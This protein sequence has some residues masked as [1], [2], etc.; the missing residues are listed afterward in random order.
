M[1]SWLKKRRFKRHRNLDGCP[2][3]RSAVSCDNRQQVCLFERRRSLRNT[4]AAHTAKEVSFRRSLTF[5]VRGSGGSS[6]TKNASPGS[7][8]RG[9]WRH[10]FRF[11]ENKKRRGHQGTGRRR[12]PHSVLA[13]AARKEASSQWSSVPLEVCESPPG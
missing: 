1:S 9:A 12:M 4:S 13:E 5:S 8:D 7:N 3:L 6:K 11:G 10:M 2:S